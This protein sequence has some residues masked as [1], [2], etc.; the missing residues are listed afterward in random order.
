ME[1]AGKRSATALWIVLLYN[2]AP[3]HRTY[4]R[5]RS[6]FP[7]A[8][9]MLFDTREACNHN[10]TNDLHTARRHLIKRVISFVPVRI[11][12]ELNDVHR[13]YTSAKKRFVVV[14]TD[15]F[16]TIDEIRRMSQVAGRL[17]D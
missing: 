6:L 4:L 7:L 12:I 13:I 15:S 5:R 16:W 9:K 1:C 17:P 10:I 3:I 2:S 11:V 14:A 8:Q